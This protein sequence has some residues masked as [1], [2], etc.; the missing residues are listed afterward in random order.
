MSRLSLHDDGGAFL[1]SSN[2]ADTPH[3]GSEDRRQTFRVS[4]EH[5]HDDCRGDWIQDVGCWP[6]KT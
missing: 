2:G 4:G 3:D 5:H 6:H 1:H